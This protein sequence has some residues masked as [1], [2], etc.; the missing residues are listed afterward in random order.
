M[1]DAFRAFP[2]MLLLA[3]ATLFAAPAGLAAL[4]EPPGAGKEKKEKKEKKEW[5]D[6]E[7]KAAVD[8]FRQAYERDDFDLPVLKTRHQVEAVEALSAVDHK[9]VAKELIGLLK[10]KDDKIWIAAVRGLG[11]MKQNAR[12]VLSRLR[13]IYEP[14]EDPPERVVA[15][16]EAFGELRDRRMIDDLVKLFIHEDD[17]VA[18][19]AVVALGKIGD[20]S[21]LPELKELFRLNDGSSRG[22]SVRVDTGTA[23]SGDRNR[24][25]AI[26]RRLQMKMRGNNRN[27]AEA[28]KTALSTLCETKIETLEELEAWMEKNEKKWK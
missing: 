3:L 14:K 25:R 20:L 2:M 24:A 9:L 10:V 19:A 15:V 6:T 23:G 8:R 13:R 21:V 11:N 22:V 7:A 26:G 1:H 27:F 28:L 16:V 4:E 5:T 17:D 12:S 18:T